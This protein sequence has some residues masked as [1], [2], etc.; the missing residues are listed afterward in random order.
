MIFQRLQRNFLSYNHPFQEFSHQMARMNRTFF[1]WLNQWGFHK[2]LESLATFF[3]LV[4]W[5][6]LQVYQDDI[7]VLT[8]CR[9]SR[10]L[11]RQ[12]HRFCLA[13]QVYHRG[14]LQ[15]LLFQSKPWSSFCASFRSLTWID[16]LVRFLFHHHCFLFLH[17]LFPRLTQITRTRPFR[18]FPTF[19]NIFSL[20]VRS[21]DQL[22]QSFLH[23]LWARPNY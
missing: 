21:L 6:C 7:S 10:Y 4:L 19:Q 20:T 14:C 11:S 12:P 8:S 15:V 23:F 2:L 1:F 13:T 16:H 9:P 18:L 5:S 22:T 3:Y 17:L